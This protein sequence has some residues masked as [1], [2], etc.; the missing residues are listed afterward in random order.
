MI[1]IKKNE[2][3][4][5][6]RRIY[7]HCVDVTDGMTPETGEADGQPQVSVNGDAFGTQEIIGVLV[8]IGNG[9]YYAELTQAGV[10][11]ADRSIIES[12][13]KSANTAEA[14]GT[15]VQIMEFPMDVSAATLALEAGGNLASVLVD[16]NELQG[17]ISGSKLPAQVKGTD[18]IDFSATQKTSLNAATPAS[19]Q[20]AVASV[21]AGVTVTTNNDKTGYTATVSD[22]T[23]FSL[24]SAGVLAIWHTLLADIVTALTIGKKLKDWVL[25][26][27]SKVLISTDAQD[28]SGTLDV[29]VKTKTS[30]LG[31][32]AQE[33]LD[34][35][36]EADMALTD[37]DPPTRTE[38][39]ADKDTIIANIPSVTGLATEANA[40]ANK[41]AVISA[42]GIVGGY[43]DTE[44]TSII[45][46]L[47]ALQT[48]LGDPSVDGTTTYA[49]LLLIKG[50]VDDLESRL[51]ATRA[52][53]ID[54]LSG[55]AIA[56]NS[57]VAKEAT[58][59]NATYG[60][61]ALKDLLDAIDTSTELQARFTEIKGSGW[62]T[63]TLKVIDGKIDAIDI[64][65]GTGIR[66]V[67]V[68]I[69]LTSTVTPIA[70]VAIQIWNSDQTL[71]VASGISDLL[72]QKVFALDDATYKVRLAKIGSNFTVPESLVVDGTTSETYYGDVID[73]GMPAV[74]NSCRVWLSLRNQDD[75]TIPA[76]ADVEITATIV[77]LPYDYNGSLHRG[78]SENCT[79]D[80]G[81]ATNGLVYWD[82]AWSSTVS[83]DLADF[84]RS[85][86]LVK[87]IVPAETSINLFLIT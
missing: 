66:E 15:T 28:L 83:F 7:F 12:R 29:N 34:V 45:N 44:I 75:S 46:A 17:L 50:Y 24:S 82:L 60:L 1:D 79:F 76:E 9:R 21:A 18:D 47:T 39:A 35:N 52:G 16:T 48:D 8:A 22:K 20:G 49:Q 73:V 54:N 71:L 63:E 74:G 30:T 59:A 86:K 65:T 81:Y 23:G 38:A 62:T 5:S 72:G 26:A 37:Y 61:S 68:Q 33:K 53:Y 3:T 36:A 51:T 87:K 2:A 70:S 69:Y 27:D 67:T 40:I 58:L 56:L 31:L 64:G 85:G 43:V 55:G 11:I 14:V 80:D 41:D 32:T 4:A 42:V 19:V 6:L 84:T 78:D 77:K 10:N 25:G 13:Y 57:T